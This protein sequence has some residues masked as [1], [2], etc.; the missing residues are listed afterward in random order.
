MTFCKNIEKLSN[1]DLE[2]YKDF[3]LDQICGKT[4]MMSLKE[5]FRCKILD[6][7]DHVL[8]EIE[9]RETVMQADDS[10]LTLT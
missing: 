1:E 9:K 10:D 3:L 8:Q 4:D 2:R 5:G 7:V 6:R